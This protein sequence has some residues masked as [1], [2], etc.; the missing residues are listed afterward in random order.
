MLG[1]LLNSALLLLLT[2]KFRVW[3]DSL[4][5]P[6]FSAVAQP[7]EVCAPASSST[8]W[9]APLVKDGASLTAVTVMPMVLVLSEIAVLPPWVALVSMVVRVRV[10]VAT[11]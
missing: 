2:I 1:W 10:A 11:L 6:L 3:P 9:L 7:I 4:A 5:A 8:V